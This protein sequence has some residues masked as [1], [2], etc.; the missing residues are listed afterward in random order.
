MKKNEAQSYYE[1]AVSDL[2]KYC[3][4][5]TDLIAVILDETYPFRVQFLPDPQ[6]TIFG[7]ENVDENGEIN[8]LT[9]TVGL[10]T[11]VK[12]TL[13]FKMDSKQLKKLIKLAEAIG[14][15]YYQ[16]YREQQGERNTPRRPFMKAMEGFTAEEAS[17][18]VC[19]N[20]EHPIV[21]QW[22]RGCKPDYCQGCG[23][24]IEWSREPA[25]GQTAVTVL[26]RDIEENTEIGKVPH[27]EDGEGAKA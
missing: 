22:A 25:G 3:D 23:Q 4:K 2:H 21:N 27:N 26:L 13:K 11:T 24:A 17:E 18:L 1:T 7:N 12:S 8:D 19:P 10:T 5:Q 20:C 6:Q 15:L 9:V 16:A 14:I